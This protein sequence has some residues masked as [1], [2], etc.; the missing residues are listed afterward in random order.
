[1]IWSTVSLFR[2][3]FTT[4][5]FIRLATRC[6]LTAGIFVFCKVLDRLSV[7]ENSRTPKCSP[8]KKSKVFI[9]AW[10]PIILPRTSACSFWSR[11]TIHSW[12]KSWVIIYDAMKATCSHCPSCRT[13]AYDTSGCRLFIKVFPFCLPIDVPVLEK[14]LWGLRL[15][16]LCPLYLGA[17]YSFLLCPLHSNLM[18]VHDSEWNEPWAERPGFS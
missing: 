12:E 15:L 11:Q 7:C 18:N 17:T 10:H 9:W 2:I 13:K 16:L 3:F 5:C 8:K 14:I 4:S 1:M 6:P